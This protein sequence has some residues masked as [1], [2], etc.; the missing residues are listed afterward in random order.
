[1]KSDRV[2]VVFL[3]L[4]ATTLAQTQSYIISTYAGGAPPPT[5]SPALHMWIGYPQFLAADAAG[6]I[7][8]STDYD[9]SFQYVFKMDKDGVVTR[10]AGIGRAGFSGDGLPAVNAQLS[11]PAGL[12]VD[13]DGN[14]FIADTVNIRIRKVSPD[15]II[16]TVA[17]NGTTGYSGDG[18][19]AIN[20]Q[21]GAAPYGYVLFAPMNIAVDSAGNLF[22]ADYHRIRKVS[23]DGIIN[24]V[25]D[26]ISGPLAVDNAGNLFIASNMANPN[27]VVKVAPDGTMTTVAGGGP[28]SGNTLGW[29]GVTSSACL[30]DLSGDGGPATQTGFCELRSLALDS[31]GNLFVG[32]AYYVDPGAEGYAWALRKISSDG[33]ITT[34][35]GNANGYRSV[36]DGEPATSGMLFG[37]SVALDR[38]G[39]IFLAFG[40]S[41]REITPDGIINHVAGGGFGNEHFSGDGG[42]ATSAQLFHPN[43]VA[44]DGSGNLFIADQN[45]RVRK[46][47][48]DGIITTF[49][50]G[51]TLSGTAADGGPATSAALAL[52]TYSAEFSNG[53]LA[54]DGA[55]N[56]F[57]VDNGT[58]IRQVSPDGIIT[59]VAGGGTL[60]G[61]Q[62]DGGPA[63]SVHFKRVAGIAADPAGN[64][65]IA[66]PEAQRVRKVTPDGII[67]TFAGTGT[68]GPSGDGGLATR[69]QLASPFAVAADNAGNVFIADG[70]GQHLR[71]VTPAGFI[72]TIAGNG[73]RPNGMF[74]QP[75]GDGGPALAAVLYMNGIAADSAGDLFLASAGAASIREITSDG[76]INTIAGSTQPCC[77]HGYSGD[78]GAATQTTFGDTSSVAVDRA[79]NVYI[80]DQFNNAVRVL[81]PVNGSSN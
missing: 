42:P 24:T 68:E 58:L 75:S 50:G 2:C 40:E 18:G 11:R 56:L 72:Y 44:V 37:S 64:L 35:A 79:G 19:P 78:G 9:A 76:Y 81:R 57:I 25:V 22:I 1:M 12:A 29:T 6:N 48:P 23:P 20:A 4:A 30:D 71:Q 33:I 16:S 41:I 27:V 51:G 54:V 21:L 55:G 3:L 74:A 70:L 31:A 7:Y 66:E 14:L 80:A 45:R 63:T 28:V 60:D 13:N 46:V 47:T 17:G 69:A 77:T 65:Y 5:P 10:V 8:F 67:S 61:S 49:A 36:A 39:N 15:G 59:T 73:K 62:A 26:Q 52:N 38:A 34:V 53:L 32:E 43:S